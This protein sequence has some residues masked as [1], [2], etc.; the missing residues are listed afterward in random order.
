MKNRYS[1][2]LRRIPGQRTRRAC[3][4]AVLGLG[5]FRSILH[6]FKEQVPQWLSLKEKFRR[7]AGAIA[8]RTIR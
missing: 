1:A 6:E 2:R 5:R 7:I 3:A 8:G 4:L